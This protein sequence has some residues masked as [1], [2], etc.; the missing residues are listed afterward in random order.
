VDFATCFVGNAVIS[1]G[2]FLLQDATTEP[3][4]GRITFK[5]SLRNQPDVVS[6]ARIAISIIS[7]FIG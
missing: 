4:G 5:K 2:I 3:T 1:L 7:V 6:I